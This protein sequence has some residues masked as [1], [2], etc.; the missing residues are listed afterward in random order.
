MGGNNEQRERAREISIEG[1]RRVG[2]SMGGAD[3]PAERRL[4]LSFVSST[5]ALLLDDDARQRS[6][7]E[8]GGLSDQ[9]L[10]E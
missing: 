6:R 5:A 3:T 7:R 4:P 10:S 9:R 1:E 8:N 2:E